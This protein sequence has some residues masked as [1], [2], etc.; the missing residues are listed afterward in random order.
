MS[1][2]LLTKNINASG[3]DP[4]YRLVKIQPATIL[5]TNILPLEFCE[6]F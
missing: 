5:L 1:M 3:K 6:I 4:N 2:T